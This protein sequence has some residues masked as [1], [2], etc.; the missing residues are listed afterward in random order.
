MTEDE[1][2]LFRMQAW[3]RYESAKGD[4]A[5]HRAKFTGWAIITERLGRNLQYESFNNVLEEY[6]KLPS[7][8]ELATSI[9]E[10]QAA[11]TRFS[12]SFQEAKQNGFPVE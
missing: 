2:N 7:D 11:K 9:T 12:Q 4:L 8:E 10:L 5:A 6:S 3:T 1:K